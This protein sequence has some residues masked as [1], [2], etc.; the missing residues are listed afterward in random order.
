LPDVR[1]EP[2]SPL[3]QGRLRRRAFRTG[4]GVHLRPLSGVEEKEITVR[5]I[6]IIDLS[7]C[8]DCESCVEICPAVFRRNEEMDYIETVDLPE[9]PEEE[10]REA[11]AVCPADCITW[12]EDQE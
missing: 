12:E 11:V 4:A 3:Q 10:I 5:R 2:L 8:T 9:Y 7:R 1:Q 6:P